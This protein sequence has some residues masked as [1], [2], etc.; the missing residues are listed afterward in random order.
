MSALV[1][2]LKELTG[3]SDKVNLINST[4]SGIEIWTVAP[5]E[6]NRQKVPIR[7]YLFRKADIIGLAMSSPGGIK[8]TFALLGGKSEKRSI[9][10]SP[11]FKEALGRIKTPE[12]SV[13]F[14]DMKALLSD[15]NEL[16]KFVAKEEAS[17]GEGEPQE[18]AIVRKALARFDV[19]DY[20]ITTIETDGR[21]ELT[22]T[23][24]VLQPGKEN[25]P[26]ARVFLDRKPFDPFDQYIPVDAT[27]FWVNGLIDVE[28]LYHVVVDFI[29]KEFPEGAEKIEKWNGWL[30]EVG[31]DPQQDLFSWW[32]GEAVSV[33]LPAAVVTPMSR[34]DSVLMIRVKDSELASQKVGAGIDWVSAKL[35]AHG[36]MLMITPAQVNAEGFREITHPMLAMFVRP[37]VGVKDDWLFLGTSAAAINKCLDVAAGKAPSIVQNKRFQEEGL[38]AKGPVLSVSFKDLTNLG[39]EIAGVVGIIGMMGGLMTAQIPDVPDD[40]PGAHET[41][42]VKRVVQKIM[43]IIMKLGPVLQKIDFFSS[44]AS[45]CT[46]DGNIVRTEYVTTYK[47]PPP[48]EEKAVPAAVPAQ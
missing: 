38:P 12:D 16:M 41:K 21:R 35:Q 6:E 3:L 4:M 13:M 47:P 5:P 44:S 30:A 14:F 40:Q 37:V 45:V 46:V 24:A 22:H 42:R 7:L 27:G 11:R 15:M 1:A 34:T 8:D 48:K 20:V 32:S 19:L 33:T 28:R 29:Q 2:I 36:Q 26:L 18:V 10:K 39:Q 9:I 25:S 17:C 31:F 43:G 23:V